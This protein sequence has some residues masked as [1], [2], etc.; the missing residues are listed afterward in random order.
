VRNSV[1]PVEQESLGKLVING[2][3]AIVMA[4]GQAGAFSMEVLQALPVAVYVTDADGRITFFNEAAAALWGCRPELGKSEFCGSWKL[5]WPDG[6]PLSHN[7][8]PMALALGQRRPIRGMEAVAERPDGTRVSFIPYPTPLIDASGQLTGA[9]NMLA[10]ISHIKST[11]ASLARH[12]DE[13]AALY[14]F[15]DRL[16]RAVSSADVHDAGLDAIIDALH[17]NR[18]SILLFDDCGVMRFVASR[19]LSDA[20]RRAVEGHSPW[21]RRVKDPQ[22]LCIP[23]VEAADFP[24]ELKATVKAEGIA[25]LAF[26]P[27][28][29]AGELIGKFMAY[30]DA[31]HVFSS[32]EIALAVTIAR[33]LG[34]SIERIRADQA[35]RLLASIIETSDDGIASK[36]LNGIVTSWNGAAER[37]FGYTAAEMIGRPLLTVIPP[38]RHGEE[39]EILAKLR[40]GERIDHFETVRQ[41]KDG[42]LIDVSITVSPIRDA[43]GKIVGASKMVRDIRERKQAQARQ[44]LLTREIQ[45]RTKNL[46]AVVLAVVSR[47]FAGKQSV[48]EAEA[49]VMTRLR[50]LGHTHIMLIEQEWRGADLAQIVRS[51]M[52]PYGDRVQV[53]GA[54]LMLSAKPAQNFALA[55]HELATNAAKY[56]ALSNASGRVHVAWLTDADRLTFSWRERGGPPVRPRAHKGFGSVVLEHVMGEHFEALPEM[57]FASGGLTYSLTTS[58]SSVAPTD[59]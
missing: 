56:G 3:D 54:S 26:I 59:E 25:A 36:D 50:S 30:Y 21:T 55:V 52:S 40:R 42:S 45:H 33:Q 18:A 32:S 53:E 35:G 46:F 16:F 22:P 57:D 23:D 51:E 43:A 15:T 27:V 24:D 29:A 20:Y 9:I 7:E 4:S 28:V 5:Y 31:P 39:A 37:I 14:Q 44:E 12:R 47:S 48:G 19:G 38:D 34:F 2:I 8:C 49:A 17:C 58:L 13:Q 1:C 11:Y 6:T 10:D 41:R